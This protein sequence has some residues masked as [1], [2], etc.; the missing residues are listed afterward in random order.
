MLTGGVERRN[1]EWN[2]LLNVTAAPYVRL[3]PANR[4]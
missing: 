4:C 1:T 3:H 2:G